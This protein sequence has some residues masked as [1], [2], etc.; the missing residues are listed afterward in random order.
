MPEEVGYSYENT[1]LL[2]PVEA[3]L[4]VTGVGW[5]DDFMAVVGEDI[6]TNGDY[7]SIIHAVA[8][9][10]NL[11]SLF[12][13]KFYSDII[14]NTTNV[15]LE[16]L[17]HIYDTYT[18]SDLVHNSIMLATTAWTEACF[19]SDNTNCG[20]D[21][22]QF[23]GDCCDDTP[24]ILFSDYLMFRETNII[25]MRC[26]KE[27]YT[28]Y[29]GY[30]LM[31]HPYFVD[32]VFGQNP[33]L[34]STERY[35]LTCDQVKRI[36]ANILFKDRNTKE[37]KYSILNSLLYSH[38]GYI[39]PPKPDL[40]DLIDDEVIDDIDD[41]IDDIIIEEDD[42]IIIEEHDPCE[43]FYLDELIV[44]DHYPDIIKNIIRDVTKDINTQSSAIELATT[45]N[46]I[47]K[48]I[49]SIV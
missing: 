26:A 29:E 30:N 19:N 41:I 34:P 2:N 31:A 38:V 9:S 12:H 16:S 37:G 7:I 32:N 6:P 11:L 47:K 1:E 25:N 13:T 39:E 28:I 40:S 8:M 45:F 14:F 23:I 44:I 3:P 24:H 27:E 33:I 49:K 35:E 20:F 15:P 21:G 5:T 48:I 4:W 17:T 46:K 43:Y 22:N 42:D 10:F 36:R 18:S